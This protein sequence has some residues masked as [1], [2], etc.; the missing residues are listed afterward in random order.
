MLGSEFRDVT[1]IG[2]GATFGEEFAALDRS[3]RAGLGRPRD[4]GLRPASGA[5]ERARRG[6]RSPVR[7]RPR[8]GTARMAARPQG[9]ANDALYEKLRSRYVINVETA[10]GA[11]ASKLAEAAP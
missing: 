2:R 6:A 5:L 11:A 3:C 8:R 4:F 10:A 1:R 9:A 7:G